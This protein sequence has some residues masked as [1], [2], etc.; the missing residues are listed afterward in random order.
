MEER[1]NGVCDREKKKR[2][3]S[4]RQLIEWKKSCEKYQYFPVFEAPRTNEAI[5]RW[6]FCFT[7]GRLSMQFFYI[8]SV[9]IMNVR[10]SKLPTRNTTKTNSFRFNFSRWYFATEIGT[11]YGRTTVRIKVFF[12]HFPSMYFASS[13]SV[14]FKRQFTWGNRR[15]N[16]LI[17]WICSTF[18]LRRSGTISSS[19]ITDIMAVNEVLNEEFFRRFLEFNNQHVIPN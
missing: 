4:N 18:S 19:F 10:N 9:C 15:W 13:I 5:R 11:S 2:R 16:V 17:C 7:H 8:V 12:F 1:G 6:T 3:N 14:R